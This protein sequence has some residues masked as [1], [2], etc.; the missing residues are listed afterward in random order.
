MF[1]VSVF[2][3]VR[4]NVTENV[5]SNIEKFVGDNQVKIVH[6]D[7]NILLIRVMEQ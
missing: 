5:K 2:S 6:G 3:F 4:C 7:V 1:R